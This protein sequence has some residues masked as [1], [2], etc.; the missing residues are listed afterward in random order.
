MKLKVLH[1]KASDYESSRSGDITK[2][3][4]N[5]DPN[6]HPFERAREVAR[7]TSAVKIK[8]MFKKPFIASMD[9][10]TDSVRCMSRAHKTLTDLYTGACDGEIRYWNLSTKTC[11]RAIKAHEGF[12]RGLC[13]NPEDTFLFSCGDDK[14][15]KQWSIDKN[16][17]IDHLDI[18]MMEDSGNLVDQKGGHGDISKMLEEIPPVNTFQANSALTSI[19]HHWQ[20]PLLV[21]TGE[22]VD[23]WDHHRSAPLHSFEWGCDAVICARFNPAEPCLIASTA[24]DNSIG[25][26][27]LRGSAPIRKLMLSL[28]SNAVAWNPMEPINF[29]VANED[30]NLYTFDMRK[31]DIALNVHKDFV[32]PV[33]DV[34][35]AP[36]GKEFV[37]CSYDK[38][39]RLFSVDEGRSRDVYHTKRM[40]R[41]LCCKF[42]ADSR[43]VVSG[44]EDTNVRIWKAEAS[45]ALGPRSLR[46]KKAMAYREALIDRYK[47]LK[48][49]KRIDRHQHVPILVKKATEKKRTIKDSMRRK[50]ENKRAHSK[51]GSV[52][53][54]TERKKSIFKHLQ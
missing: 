1:H 19:D 28:R 47:N 22:T 51:E 34:D 30:H 10:H 6:L 46:E 17:R 24:A 52:P 50:E 37:G 48:E 8:A 39:I 5:A 16:R 18:D 2:F 11:T 38:T 15:I 25:L 45:A 44:S 41:V 3:I 7:A 54:E 26:Y 4:R 23:V 35:Y 9:G 32:G 13:C 21:A 42:S 49:I 20:R 29:T 36:T 40:Q 43:F 31:L 27:D 12:V 33:L 53:Y 14:V